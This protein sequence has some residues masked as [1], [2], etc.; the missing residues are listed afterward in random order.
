MSY[1]QEKSLNRHNLTF[2]QKFAG[3]K[4]WNDI[5]KVIKEKIRKSKYAH[6]SKTT[7]QIL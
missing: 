2:Q 4:G 5:F 3:Q 1:V 7:I 6:P